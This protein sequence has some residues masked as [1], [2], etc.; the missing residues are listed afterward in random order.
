VAVGIGRLVDGVRRARDRWR[1][2]RAWQRWID[3]GR[4]HP[5]PQA[6]KRRLINEIGQRHALRVLVETG[7][8]FGQTVSSAIGTFDTIY[9]IELDEA[10][11]THAS[12][13][14]ADRADVKLRRGDSARELRAVLAELREPALFWLDAHYSGD[15]TARGDQDSP[16]MQELASIA[17]HQIRTHAILIDDARLFVGRDGYPTIEECRAAVGRWWPGHR[18][19]VSDDV[20][21]VLPER[22]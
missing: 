2:R 4:P 15:G 5:I 8:N 18:Y 9:S 12:R 20:I 13:R 14:F 1:D 11:W 17:G 22:S 6:C 19:D 10:L 7:T 3:A 16:I 21:Q